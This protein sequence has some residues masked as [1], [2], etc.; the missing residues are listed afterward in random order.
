LVHERVNKNDLI[1]VMEEKDN[2][3]EFIDRE[4]ILSNNDADPIISHLSS[5]KH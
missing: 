1:V 3:F 2:P 5:S 4:K